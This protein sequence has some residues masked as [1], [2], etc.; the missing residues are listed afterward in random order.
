MQTSQAAADR[1]RGEQTDT[2]WKSAY[3]R[4]VNSPQGPEGK[5]RSVLWALISMS[6]P[7]GR[8]WAS[9]DSIANFAGVK[10]RT[11]RRYLDELEITGWLKKTPMTWRLLALEQAHLGLPL[12]DQDHDGISPDVV[13]LCR[14]RQPAVEAMEL[15]IVATSQNGQNHRPKTSSG[16]LAKLAYDPGIKSDPTCNQREGDPRQLPPILDSA[17]NE[18][19]GALCV[20]YDKHYREVYGGRATCPMPVDIAGLLG[21]HVADLAKLLRDR[22]RQ[23]S[24]PEISFADAVHRIADAAV[25]A[26]LRTKEEFLLKCKHALRA[27]RMDLPKFG[28]SA[29]DTILS[30]LAPQTT[31]KTAVT[32]T[33]TPKVV[34]FAEY[35]KGEQVAAKPMELVTQPNE[36]NTTPNEIAAKSNTTKSKLAEMAES[37]HLAPSAPAA[38]S[39]TTVEQLPEKV[40]VA[41]TTK[42]PT[43]DEIK[44]AAKSTKTKSSAKLVLLHT[45]TN[46]NSESTQVSLP[47]KPD[48]SVLLRALGAPRWCDLA[49]ATELMSG[50]LPMP[51]LLQ[52]LQSLHLDENALTSARIRAKV[53]RTIYG[54]SP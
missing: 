17:E 16:V 25:A 19:W 41:A 11:L 14:H 3:S 2:R 42:A 13:V 27:L 23:R 40:D 4:V 22:L 5:L 18:G 32:A 26:W 50:P 39:Q 52:V 8:C 34:S 43:T 7:L 45:T 47:E 30:E 46:Q 37:E 53:F 36:T 33:N 28:K 35:L 31:I 51:Q 20:S 15:R 1:V 48:P 49:F 10:I 6:D 12:P 44:A 38:L 29:V 24:G 21:G 54:R 9:Q